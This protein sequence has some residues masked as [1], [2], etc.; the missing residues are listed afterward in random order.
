MAKKFDDPITRYWLDH[1][2]KD[3]LCSL[4]G[5]RGV[6]DTRSACSPAGV[7]CGD[8]HYCLCP[9]GRSAREHKVDPKRLLTL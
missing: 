4:C 8:L 1:Y 7:L 9:N 2:T 3:G 5:N 6:I